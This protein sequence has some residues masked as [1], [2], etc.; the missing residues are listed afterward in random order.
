MSAG[1]D[2]HISISSASAPANTPR[3]EIQ[4]WADQCVAVLLRGLTRTCQS[5]A[6]GLHYA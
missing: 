2:S 1:S 3:V 4:K 5:A 6:L